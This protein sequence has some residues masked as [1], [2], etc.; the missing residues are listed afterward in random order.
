MSSD[1]PYFQDEKYKRSVD[2]IKRSNIDID[3]IDGILRGTA[4]QLFNI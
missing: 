1:F 4:I 2:Y 3:K